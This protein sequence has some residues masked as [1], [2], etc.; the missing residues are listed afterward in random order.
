LR[1]EA[2]NI[3]DA[4]RFINNAAMQLNLLT[5]NTLLLFGP[6]PALIEKRSGRYRY[7]LII[8]SSSRKSLHTHIDEWLLKL[9]NMQSP[10]KVRW[11]LDIDPQDMT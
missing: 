8:Q 9:E 3:N 5:N 7:Q 2:H 1:A 6:I 11:S 10:K 4:K